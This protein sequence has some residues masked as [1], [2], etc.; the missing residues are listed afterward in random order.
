MLVRALVK[1]RACYWGCP[2]TIRCR[3]VFIDVL[4]G[5]LVSHISGCIKEGGYGFYRFESVLRRSASKAVRLF[6]LLIFVNHAS[7]LSA[8]EKFDYSLEYLLGLNVTVASLTPMSIRETP[9]IT[10]LITKD[11][12]RALGARDLVDI[13]RMVPG[14]EFGND[15]WGVV[16]ASLRGNW[17]AEGKILLLIDGMPYNDL[18]YGNHTLG[19]R[20]P[21]DQIERIELIRGPGSVNYGGWAEMAVIN[22]HTIAAN[23]DSGAHATITM[24]T[25]KDGI[26]R[27]NSQISFRRKEQGSDLSVALF[28]SSSYR[29]NS[30]Y[31]MPDGDRIENMED[32]SDLDT[33]NLRVRYQKHQWAFDFSYDD[34]TLDMF[35]PNGDATDGVPE[36]KMELGFPIIFAKASYTALFSSNF[37]FS[38]AFSI[39]R[40]EPWHQDSRDAELVGYL[41]EITVTRYKLE[42]PFR[43]TENEWDFLAGLEVYQDR[44][45]APTGAPNTSAFFTGQDDSQGNAILEYEVKYNNW[46]TYAQMI[47]SSDFGNFIIGSRYHDNEAF[48]GSF[49]PRV[50]YTRAFDRYHF[51]ALFSQA[52]RAP[53]VG[54]INLRNNGVIAKPETTTNVEFEFGWIINDSLS[55]T[56][57]IFDIEID[58]SIFF[59]ANS[60]NDGFGAYTNGGESGTQGIEL[61]LKM[62]PGT[63]FGAINYSFYRAK[64]N[65]VDNIRVKDNIGSNVDDDVFLGHPQHKIT[66]Y[67]SSELADSLSITPSIIYLGVRNVTELAEGT[68]VRIFEEIAPQVL[69]NVNLIHR[70]KEIDGLE[71]SFAIYNLTDEKYRFVQ[72]YDGGRGTMPAKSREFLLK[73]DWS[74]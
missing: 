70:V 73:F 34:H 12:I 39:H 13:L 57:N 32:Y 15:V 54:V 50:G 26:S 59:I 35:D 69:V 52:Y 62:Q 42:M 27:R 9:G 4:Y 41:T 28:S 33:L 72:A 65:D 48:G 56:G 7:F 51:K 17:T 49:V 24:G 22:I 71:V 37:E 11:E 53:N 38:P 16:S 14:F 8:E 20:I 18:S 60:S 21:V 58:D 55:F 66:A 46:A 74:I 5:I 63:G 31:V 40:N 29:G 3:L 19:N 23:G 44:G 61:E 47:W 2:L 1:K 67:Y 10:T 68:G 45:D 25:T 6:F 36:I 30:F 64:D 43:Y